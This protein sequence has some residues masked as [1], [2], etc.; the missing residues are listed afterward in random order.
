MALVLSIAAPNLRN[1]R[2]LDATVMGLVFLAF[3]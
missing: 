2:G 3:G 1:D